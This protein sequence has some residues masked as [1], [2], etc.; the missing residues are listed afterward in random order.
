MSVGKHP[1][2]V[3]AGAG[4]IGLSIA[5]Q[6]ASRSNLQ[7]VVLEKGRS[8]GEGS[9]GASSAICRHRY[10][11]ATMIELARDGIHAYRHWGDF[12]GLQQ[13][14]AAYQEDGVLWLTGDRDWAPH[15]QHRLS[16]HGIATQVLDDEALSHAFPDYS[17]CITAPDLEYGEAHA[18]QGGALHLLEINGGYFDPVSAV[19]DLREACSQAGVE[20]RLAS[21]VSDIQTNG[22][23]LAGAVLRDGQT[24][25]T[26][27]LINATGPWCQR[28]YQRAGIDLGWDLAPVR[29]QVLYLDRPA[30][31]RGHV[32]VTADLVNGIY[33]RGQNCGQQIVLGS[34]LEKDEREQVNNA[35]DFQ[36]EV[37]DEF[38]LRK[39][40]LLH[41]R[42]P[43]LPYRGRVR[44]YCGLYTVNRDDVHPVLG[45][46][47]LPGLWAANGFS[48]HGFKLAPAIGAMFARAITGA[49]G[50]YDTAV[51]LSAFGVDRQPIE[52]AS[53]NVLA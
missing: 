9:T 41:H 27:L 21:E 52:L 51:P 12:T 14:R 35:D 16:Y 31:L 3:V 53:R 25:Q 38:E 40:H 20:V 48:G 37:D 32:P 2:V 13:P 15:E 29:I 46:T 4:I 47:T 10:T 7:V 22:G 49:K 24:V 26:P 17:S 8:L 5:W 18:C 34:V 50:S 19:E 45:E 23:R 1:D 30:T 6:I 42:L 36:R 28:L 33:F 44:G 39:L 43:G 11:S